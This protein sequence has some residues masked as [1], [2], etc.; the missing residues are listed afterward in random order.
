MYRRLRSLLGLCLLAGTLCSSVS[1][2][3]PSA[4]QMVEMLL[5]Q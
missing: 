5:M 3:E 1:R 4:E 2:A